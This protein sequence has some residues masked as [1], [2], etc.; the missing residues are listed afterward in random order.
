MIVLSIKFYTYS[1]LVDTCLIYHLIILGLMIIAVTSSYSSLTCS[2]LLCESLTNWRLPCL[3]VT[4]YW[5]VDTC[6]WLAYQLLI[7]DLLIHCTCL[8]YQLLILDLLIPAMSNSELDLLIPALPISYLLLSCWYLPCLLFT[9]S[10]LLEL[11]IHLLY[12]SITWLADTCLV[13]QFLI[14][15]F[16]A[17][18]HYGACTFRVTNRGPYVLDLDLSV[19]FWSETN[20]Y[21]I[22]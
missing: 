16:P 18:F 12:L 9:D 10:W 20:D 21:E 19:R 6:T 13:Y 14:R 7:L 11:L 15:F 22:F 5:L 8:V 4:L 17:L 2:Y 3:S 1:G